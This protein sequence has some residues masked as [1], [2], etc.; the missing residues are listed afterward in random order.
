MGLILLLVIASASPTLAL[1][2][3]LPLDS[4]WAA[5]PIRGAEG[6]VDVLLG[7]QADNEGRDVHHLLADPGEGEQVRGGKRPRAPPGLCRGR[8]GATAALP[9]KR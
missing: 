9:L 2:G 1:L 4:A 7:V 5:T 3:V 6:E 8:A